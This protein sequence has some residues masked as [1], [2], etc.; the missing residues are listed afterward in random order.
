MSN[1][2][3][4]TQ[5]GL[6]EKALEWL[7][8]QGASTV[9][10]VGI[11]G[12][13]L[14]GLHYAMTTA[15]PKHL[16]QIQTGYDRIAEQHSK[17]VQATNASH[18]KMIQ[19]LTESWEREVRALRGLP[20]APPRDHSGHN[21]G[22]HEGDVSPYLSCGRTARKSLRLVPPRGPPAGGGGG[23]GGRI[24]AAGNRFSPFWSY[25]TI[26]NG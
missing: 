23:A 6:K 25:T 10:L 19:R 14:Y 22:A 21:Q 20:A 16:E 3:N 13:L 24:I 26:I 5:R 4:G 12:S 18:E 7:F 1:G 17:E 2:N 11:L 9:L 8:Q 15:I